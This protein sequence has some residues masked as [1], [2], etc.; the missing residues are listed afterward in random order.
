MPGREGQDGGASWQWDGDADGTAEPPAEVLSG[1]AGED[2]G[3][4]L[5]R[6]RLLAGAGVLAAGGALWALTRSGGGA[7]PAPPK[8]RPT[9]LTGPEPVWTYRGP[10]AMTPERLSERPG[11]PVFFS[12]SGLQVLDPATGAVQRTLEFPVPKSDW[13]SDVGLPDSRVVIG[14]DRV[15]TSSHGHVDGRRLGDP[16]AR[17]SVPLPEQLGSTITLF[18]C[19]GDVVF[20]RAESRPF[21]ADGTQHLF[22]VRH[23][24]QAVLWSRP[25]INERPL[26]PVTSA[27]G[28]VPLLES[29]GTDARLVLL[30]T[31]TGKPVW[32]VPAE[33]STSWAVASGQHVYTNAGP[34]GL[35]ALRLE[36]GTPHWSA[37]PGPSEEWRF[38]PP[39]ADGTRVFL[40]RDDGVVVAHAVET[41]ARLWSHR[42]PFRLDRR[43]RP[44]PAGPNLYVPGPAAAGVRALDAATGE[45]RWTFRDSGPGVDVWSLSCDATHLYAG[46]DDIL[47]ALPLG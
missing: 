40:P 3:P 27:G 23:P 22:A 7:D 1:G 17:W 45:E 20:G 29:Y 15:F 46:H 4:W 37:A 34:A 43:S 19:D 47:H 26:S 44:L 5:S 32:A 39:V 16:A 28:H 35:R 11:Q 41:G 12:R 8:P 13:P 6:R 33:E 14:G 30:E 25:S 10:E 36:D 24:D 31:A 18:G 38:L 2:G 9:R 42:L 21:T